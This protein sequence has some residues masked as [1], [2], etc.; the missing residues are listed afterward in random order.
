[1][2]LRIV[3]AGV[4]DTLQ[5]EGRYGY[6]HLGINP[7]GCMD[8]IAMNI[9][10]ALV[11]NHLDEPVVEMHFPAAE[12]IFDSDAII[13]ISGGEF[14]AQINDSVVNNNQPI[15]IRSGVTL[16]FKKFHTG[17]RTYLAIKGGLK[18][19]KWLSSSSTNL[20]AAAGGYN[21]RALLKGDKLE[22][23]ETADYTEILENE[24]FKALPWHAPALS[25]YT[26]SSIRLIAGAEFNMLS[27][28]SK[29]LLATSAFLIT[30]QSD[31]MGY[32]LQGTTLELDKHVE[33][34]SSGVSKG[35]I[36]LLP[37]GQLIILMADHQTTGGY[38]RIGHV[39]R[40]DFSSVAQ[41]QSQH[42]LQLVLRDQSTAEAALYQQ[43]LD[44]LQLQNACNFRLQQ[45]LRT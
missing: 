6:Q 26:S 22:L 21:G 9:A 38:P 17:A 3:K 39:I 18:V 32:R 15:I 16:S 37:S 35:T 1:M 31:R 29:E 44:L 14:G 41:M 19:D 33:L 36:Q 4:L 43:H 27:A 10:N 7:N 30:N 42:H 34:I 2:S 40:A 25:F 28:S 13:A 45:Y 11:G 12:I 23:K 5:D 20:K 8:T 24:T